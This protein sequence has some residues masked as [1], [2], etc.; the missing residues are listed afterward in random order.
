[1]RIFITSTP[2]KLESCQVAAV[3]VVRELGHEPV[4]RDPAARPGLDPVTACGRQVALTDV[5]LAIVGRQRGR[6]PSVSL[7]GDGFRPWTY[8]EV[9]SAFESRVPVVA[10]LSTGAIDDEHEVDPEAVAVMTDLRGELARLGASFDNEESLRQVARDA[11]RSVER[12]SW[13]PGIT[14][15]DLRLRNHPPPERPSL[16]YPL[17]LPYTHPDMMAGRDHDLADLCRTLARPLTAVGLYAASG[18]GKSSLL[19]AGLVPKLRAEGQPVAF[20]RYPSEPGL[21]QRLLEDLL[22]TEHD[23]VDVDDPRAFV[24]HLIVARRLADGATPVLVIDQFEDLLKDGAE[25]T[26][27]ALGPLLAASAQRLPGLDG[28]VC[29]WLLAYR[30]EYH[31]RVVEWLQDVLRGARALANVDMSSSRSGLESIDGLPHDLSG[32]ARFAD[33]PLRPLATPPAGVGDPV[34]AAARVFLD[35]I[36]RPLDRGDFPWTFASGHAE[37]LARSFAKARVQQPHAPLGPELQVVLAHLL[38]RAAEPSKAKPQIIQVPENVAELIDRALEQHL[39]RALDL[40]FPLGQGAAARTA[41]TRALLI[42]RELADEHGRRQEGH[43]I[44][45]LARALG[46]EGH[47]VLEKFSTA[48]TR[49]VVRQ[50]QGDGQVY[51]LAH[52]RLAEVLVQVVDEGRWAELGIDHRL[53]GL[54]RFVALQSRLF[55]SGDVLQATAVPARLFASISA[56][57]EVLL[58]HEAQRLWW[59]ACEVARRADRQRRIVRKTLA[60]LVLTLV[61][62]GAWTVADRR[63]RKRALLEEVADGE[64]TAA[65]AALDV[66]TQQRSDEPQEALDRLRQ[67]EFPFD[68]FERGLG[69]V[70]EARRADALVRVAELALPILE[71]APEDPKHIASLVWA[72]DFF[73]APDPAFTERARA[74]RD[75]ALEPLRRRRPPPPSPAP[76]DPDW[77]DIPAGTFWM[78]TAPGEGRDGPHMQ[79]E[80]PRHQVSISP[81]RMSTHEVTNAEYRCLVPEH[82]GQA[83]YPATSINWYQA[84]TYAAWAGGRLPTEAEWEYAVRARCAFAYCKRDG[85]EA[86]LDEVAWWTGNSIDP[87]T[88]EPAVQPVKQLEPNPFGL[89]DIHGNID[90]WNANWYGPYPEATAKNPPGPPADPL[91]NRTLR[92]SDVLASKAWVQ[93]SGRSATVP[94][95]RS[96]PIGLR[97]MIPEF[98]R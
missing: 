26:L 68:I 32:P 3:D 87:E 90:E 56:H 23:E 33:W 1:M 39:C 45:P 69:G 88:G 8:W 85:S 11:L 44:S 50:Q 54:R 76:G 27:A 78:G 96:T 24:D 61:S 72:L 57:R 4:L 75:E 17:L 30:Q 80:Y 29:R 83:D 19:A 67:R 59:Q 2:D 49:L 60:V 94:T 66:W 79:D 81:F 95:D 35:A 98:E 58:W 71:A 64:P 91:N 25:A 16:P 97:V 55:A 82:G 52:D 36:E 34:E 74:L 13:T 63:E 38:E 21:K 41:R 73:A 40:A 10:L 18:T 9:K 84:Y 42:L 48:Q 37:R 47:E 22:E 51:V 89:W 20:D 93:A 12:Q 77:A 43:A 14:P 53:L 92:S 15:G 5:V 62:L 7:G 86:E 28:P 70:A 65:F 6:V 31:G 46:K